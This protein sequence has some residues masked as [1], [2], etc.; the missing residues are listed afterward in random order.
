MLNLPPTAS[1]S[2]IREKYKA[3]SVVFH[4][5]KQQ[6][7]QV[8]E[9]ASKKFLEIQKAYEGELVTICILSSI[10]EAGCLTMFPLLV[11]LSDPFL[12]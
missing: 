9:A 7:F 11:V 6:D 5:D 8:K 10:P 3:L 1:Q 2:E 12:R 4:P